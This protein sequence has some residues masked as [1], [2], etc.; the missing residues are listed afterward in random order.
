LTGAF[1]VSE[2]LKK[3]AAIVAG[4]L[5]A[6]VPMATLNHWLDGFV[7]RQA[8]NEVDSAAKRGVAITDYRV[9]LVVTALDDLAARGVGS[10][11]ADH[12]EALRSANLATSPIKE[13]SILAPDGRTLCSDLGAALDERVVLAT[14]S[15]T[16]RPDAV[17]ELIQIGETNKFIRVRRPAIAGENFLAA[18][19]PT[20]LLV[21]RTSSRGGLISVHARVTMRDGTPIGDVGPALDM[22]GGLSSAQ[23]SDLYGLTVDASVRR[24]ALAPDYQ[25]LQMIGAFFTG[26][27]ALTLF[28]FAILFPKRDPGNPI[29]ELQQALKAGEFVPYYQPVVDITTG[30][31]RGAEVLMRWRKPD[32][33]IAQPS[34]FIPL[35]ESS[36]LILEMTRAIMRSVRDEMGPAVAERPFLRLGFNLAARH[37]MNEQIVSDVREIFEG[38]PVRLSQIVLEVTERQSLDSLTSARRVI[39]ALQG[40]GIKVA[41]DDIG[42]GHAGLSYMLKLGV[43]IIKIDKM[44]I[45]ALGQD[46]SSTTIIE[47][48]VDLARSMRMD[49]IAEGVEN[50]EQVVALRERGIRAAQGY[51][52]APPLPGSS[53]L[54]LLAAIDP[55]TGT[56]PLGLDRS[57]GV[58]ALSPRPNVAA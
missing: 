42:A 50:F 28:A 44:F 8:Q 52:F 57:G 31:V 23:K 6:G 22:S 56:T 37:F 48:L 30:R 35:A 34:S 7:E 49:V 47:T 19:I 9:G 21:P 26:I 25:D 33:T 18:A 32:G 58:I 12:L 16:A 13:L 43:D 24:S 41:I 27:V 20:D 10:C 14:Q 5:I 17:L 38:S 36:G 55:Q 51:V 54:E 40:L 45:D 4:M 3:I 39:A 15:M 53:F 1:E 2:S 46:H 11:R 29:A